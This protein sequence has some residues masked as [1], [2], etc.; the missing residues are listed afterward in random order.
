MISTL[1][2][3]HMQSLIDAGGE[4]P[5]VQDWFGNFVPM[6]GGREAVKAYLAREFVVDEKFDCKPP[7]TIHEEV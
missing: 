3:W 7:F 4:W 6:Y 1:T 2:I 5:V